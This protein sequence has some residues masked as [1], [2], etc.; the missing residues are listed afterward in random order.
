MT[1]QDRQKVRDEVAA[2]NGYRPQPVPN[3]PEWAGRR[4]PEATDEKAAKAAMKLRGLK[5]S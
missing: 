5:T 3:D 1:S 2:L 4:L